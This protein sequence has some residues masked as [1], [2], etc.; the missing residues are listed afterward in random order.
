M[1]HTGVRIPTHTHTLTHSLTHSLTH[2]L[3]HSHSPTHICTNSLTQSHS[4]THSHTR[5]PTHSLCIG[6]CWPRKA[7]D[8][9]CCCCRY[10]KGVSLTQAH[11]QMMELPSGS[12]VKSKLYAAGKLFMQQVLMVRQPTHTP[13][14]SLQLSAVSVLWQAIN[15]DHLCKLLQQCHSFYGTLAANSNQTR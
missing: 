2:T 14:A 9:C 11:T 8:F 3:T 13:H 6:L 1:D 15:S 7:Y 5:A 10:V 4:H 12:D